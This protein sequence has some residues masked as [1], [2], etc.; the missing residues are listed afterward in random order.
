MTH[1][2]LNAHA[3]EPNIYFPALT[4]FLPSYI[5]AFVICDSG[6]RHVKGAI[7]YIPE[8]ISVTYASSFNFH[9]YFFFG[10]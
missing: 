7:V 2:H 4:N 10:T 1:G 3:S 9:N 8:I 6:I 5:I